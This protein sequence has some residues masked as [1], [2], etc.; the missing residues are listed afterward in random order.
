MSGHSKW[1]NIQHRKNTQ[2]AKKGKI[3][4]KIIR[5]IT[6]ASR[7][8]K[9]DLSNHRLRLA[10]DKALL[11]NMSRETIERAIKRGIGSIADVKYESIRYEGYGPCGIAVM[12]ETITD[13]RNRTIAE[14]RHIFSK[15]GGHLS[16]PGSV[17]FKFIERGVL[18]YPVGCQEEYIISNAIEF[19]VEDIQSYP[20]GSV[21]V[22]TIPTALIKIRDAMECLGLIPQESKIVQLPISTINLTSEDTEKMVKMLEM[23]E[24]LDD[25][26]IVYS[27]AV[28]ESILGKL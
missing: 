6:V 27:D 16:I 7:L 26:Q 21:D 13:N 28:L 9:G 12:V 18:H 25:V 3:F 5:A 10:I 19:G 8:S 1:A 23:L 20:D 15:C 4:T 17:A 24:N 11:T 22:F 14:I 2:D